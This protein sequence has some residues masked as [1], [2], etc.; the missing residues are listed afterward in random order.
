METQFVKVEEVNNEEFDLLLE[1]YKMADN[2][3]EM[4]IQQRDNL[5]IQ[6]MVAYGAL[7]SAMSVDNIL[8][9]HI[10]IFVMPIISLY[11]CS[12][13]F[14]SYD[15]HSRLVYFIKNNVEFQLRKYLNSKSFLWEEFCE[16]DRQFQ[17]NSRLGG[18]KGYF[19]FVNMLSPVAACVL[20]FY[21]FGQGNLDKFVSFINLSNLGG[22]AYFA[23]MFGIALHENNK[24][25]GNY[26]ENMM[27]LI[28]K[29]GYLNKQKRLNPFSRA[30][31]LDRDGTLHVDKVETR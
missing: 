3:L 31:F 10:C 8:L 19:K 5:G 28:A 6:L 2:Q 4:R 15:V 22:L 7:I 17:K 29:R 18:R 1:S 27:D 21:F 26:G 23:L 16:Y 9:K 25:K 13:V 14:S 24:H 30:V 12:Q 11:F 20:Y